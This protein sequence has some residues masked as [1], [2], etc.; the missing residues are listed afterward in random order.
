MLKT[1]SMKVRGKDIII[2]ADKH[3]MARMLVVAQNRSRDL[4]NVLAYEL[5]PVPWSISAIDG[6]F[7]KTI[8]SSLLS[9]LENDVFSG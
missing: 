2:Q 9:L 4:R 6:G 7:A 5:G 1:K 8:K 3:L